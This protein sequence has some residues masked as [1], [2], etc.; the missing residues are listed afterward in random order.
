MEHIGC[1]ALEHRHR[2]AAVTR[3][4]G[5][6]TSSIGT[7]SVDPHPACRLVGQRGIRRPVIAH[8]QRG[9]QPR[10]G[11]L[12][13]PSR[14][15]GTTSPTTALA[16]NRPPD[17]TGAT[18]SISIRPA[19]T[20]PLLHPCGKRRPCRCLVSFTAWFFR[21]SRAYTHRSARLNHAE[22]DERTGMS[23]PP[24]AMPAVSK[25]DPRESS[26]TVHRPRPSSRAAGCARA[27]L[28]STCAGRGTSRRRTCSRPSI[29]RLWKLVGC[30]PVAMLGQVSPARLEELAGDES[31]VQ[32]LD[33]LAADLDNYLTRP[34]WYQQLATEPGGRRVTGTTGCCPTA[35][36]TSRWSSV[37]PRCCRTI[38]AAWA[39]WQATTSSRRRISACR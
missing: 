11:P 38:P 6:T 37:S 15:T 28:R 2:D 12:A 4:V 32:R 1:R 26:P 16:G 9:R 27:A 18:S 29:Q 13:T 35:S 7:G 20:Y 14:D 5:F 10:H 31:F 23:T 24:C 33:A 3:G 34:L 39:S 17:T 19:V 25:V 30:D 22:D 21:P 36:P 8:H